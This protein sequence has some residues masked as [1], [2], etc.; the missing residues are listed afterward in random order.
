[1]SRRWRSEIDAV[2]T[3]RHC[4]VSVAPGWFAAA[5]A[6]RGR[7]D[8]PGP[9][10]ITDALNALAA[11]TSEKLPR[12]ACLT[13]PDEQVYFAVLPAST[14]WSQ[15]MDN[16]VRHFTESLGRH[17]LH[18]RISLVDAGRSWLAAAIEAESLQAWSR[19]FL[20]AGIALRAIEP[21]LTRDLS[22]FA[23]ALPNS[24]VLV[25]ARGEG[26]MLLHL[27]AGEVVDLRWE[28]CGPAQLEARVDAFAAPLLRADPTLEIA[29][30]A[31]SAGEWPLPALAVERGWRTLQPPGLPEPHA[32]QDA[33][34]ALVA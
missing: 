7:G 33:V 16:A 32:Q 14:P 30:L 22:H 15:R 19:P 17:D 23:A 5:S 4:E 25:M 27:H 12:R 6:A 8:G 13:V 10:A 2:L 18:V 24:G 20:D 9:Q 28:R 34:P 21:A 29:L 11:S 26:A 31:G 3:V 1:M